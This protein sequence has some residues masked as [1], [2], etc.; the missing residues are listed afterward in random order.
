MDILS[1]P[2]IP[3]I[4]VDPVL[5]MKL[6]KP[7]PRY[8]SYPTAPEWSSVSQDTYST[9]LKMLDTSNKKI[10][11]YFHIP[12]CTTMCLYCGCSVILNRKP[13]RQEQYIAYLITEIELIANQFEHKHTITQLHFGGGTPTL[14]TEKQ[15]DLIFSTLSKYFEID[16]DGEISI[17]IDPR[18]VIGDNGEKLKYLRQKGFNRISFGVQDTNPEVQEAVKRRQTYEMTAQTY[19][20]A[21]ELKFKGINIDLIYGL[22]YQTPQSFDDTIK[23]IISLKPDRVALFS[24]AKVPWLKPHQNAIKEDT[25]PSI[26]QKFEIYINARK[27]FLKDGYIAIGMDHFGLEQDELTQAY[28]N[29]KLHRNFHGYT[30]RLADNMISFGITAI[31]E[32]ENGYFQNV[33]TLEE[34]YSALDQKQF[35]ISKGKELTNDDKIRRWVIQSLMCHFELDKIL[36]EKLHGAKFEEYFSQEFVDIQE[37]VNDGLIINTVEK[38][39]PTF[40]GRLFIRNIAATFD[41]YLRNKQQQRKFSQSI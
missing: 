6:H 12:F 31:G 20:W 9:H 1:T 26:E 21:R 23:K 22:P 27:Q 19:A 40:Y 24:Y 29:H 13:E 37:L 18:T 7:V 8:T 25:L 4:E 15:F 38:L 41:H 35:P 33:K 36:F 28:L 11:I 34:Y 3:E 16:F 14:L 17:E 2:Y 5:L 30:L 39:Q 32:V 10:S